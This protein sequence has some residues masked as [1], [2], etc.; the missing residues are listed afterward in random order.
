MLKNAIGT[1]PFSLQFAYAS[2]IGVLCN[3]NI[4]D[5]EITIKIEN[6]IIY[7]G[8]NTHLNNLFIM[9]NQTLEVDIDG[10]GSVFISILEENLKLLGGVGIA[11]SEYVGDG[12]LNEF[13]IPKGLSPANAKNELI[14]NL[15]GISVDFTLSNDKT[16]I[17]LSDPPYVGGLI[18]IKII[19]PQEY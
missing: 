4:V 6:S 7:K 11:Q 9:Q 15:D 18:K 3:P 2:N 16:K 5:S 12:I 10:G 14:V 13:E 19:K 1:S 17:I 8:T